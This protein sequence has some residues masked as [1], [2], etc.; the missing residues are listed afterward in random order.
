[1]RFACLSATAGVRNTT[2]KIE[3]AMTLEQSAVEAVAKIRTS[4]REWIPLLVWGA[5]CLVVA[6]DYLQA[7]QHWSAVVL[8]VLSCIGTAAALSVRTRGVDLT[9]GAAD[10]RGPLRGPSRRSLPWQEV[11]AVVRH[12]HLNGS[13]VRLILESGEQVGLLAPTTKWVFGRAKY[14]RDF[15]LIDGWWRAH[16]GE[17]WRPVL[18]EAPRPPSQ[19]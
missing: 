8:L 13:S 14:E 4:G 9:P 16:R 7:G 18:P 5:G 11:Q 10:V 2:S 3:A 19:G 6:F 1:M 15:D 17:S 12:P